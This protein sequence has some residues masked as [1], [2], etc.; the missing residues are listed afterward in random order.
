MDIFAF[1]VV[2][3]INSN[4]IGTE[5]HELTLQFDE[6]SP[7]QFNSH[8]HRLLQCKIG[9]SIFIQGFSI[10]FIN[11]TYNVFHNEHVIK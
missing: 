6:K 11:F 10:D 4:Q 2:E 9:S 7:I 5:K 8:L 1:C 3:K